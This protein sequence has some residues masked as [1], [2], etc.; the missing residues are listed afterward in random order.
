M[1]DFP[2]MTPGLIT[3]L[4]ITI[5]GVGLTAYS[6][7]DSVRRYRWLK[8]HK[9]PING[10]RKRYVLR[11]FRHES[12]R[13]IA[14]ALLFYATVITLA[15]IKTWYPQRNFILGAVSIIMSVNS[16]WDILDRWLGYRGF[17]RR[18]NKEH[19]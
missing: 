17:I 1:L 10:S 6:V 11:V 2:N 19:L 13:L 7:R 5:S 16:G 3:L 4:V 9:P 8:S 18:T 15:E 12:F 14:Q